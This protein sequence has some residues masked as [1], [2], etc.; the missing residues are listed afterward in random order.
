VTEEHLDID[1][2]EGTARFL[3]AVL[4]CIGTRLQRTG[5]LGFPVVLLALKATGLRSGCRLV[6]FGAR[7]R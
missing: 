5:R 7:R 1:L 2:V 3:C 4:D 6:G